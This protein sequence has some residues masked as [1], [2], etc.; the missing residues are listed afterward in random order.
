MKR[1]LISLLI[2]SSIGVIAVAGTSS[3]FSD[4][5]VATD[6]TFQAGGVDLKIDSTAHYN[7]MICDPETHTWQP[8]N[9]E[10]TP[11]PIQFPI[12]GTSCFGSWILT[13][14][15]QERFFDF[16][17]L[18]PGD[19]GE[20]TISMHVVDNN[21]WACMEFSNFEN[22]DPN[23][24]E[25]ES[26][27]D[28]TEG[29]GE[30]ELAQVLQFFAWWDDGDN[31]FEPNN[32]PAEVPLF[33]PTVQTAEQVFTSPGITLA[34]ST[35]GD[36]PIAGGPLEDDSFTSYI[37]WQWCLG[38]LSV[39]EESGDITCD[40]SEIGNEVQTDQLI[41]DVS[42]RIEQARNN[43]DFVCVEDDC[44]SRGAGQA[45]VVEETNQALRRDGSPV[46]TSRSDP[47]SLL[48][49]ADSIG[50]PV[51]GN[52]YSLGFGGSVVIGFAD[53]VFDETGADLRVYEVTGGRPTYPNELARVEVAQT[54]TGPWVELGTAD[55]DK[56]ADGDGVGVD[57][58]D[59]AGNFPW[60]RY[61]RITDVTEL[62]EFSENSFATADGFDID[63]VTAVSMCIDESEQN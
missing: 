47:N 20:N 33:T 26:E 63:A 34:D 18:K 42:F 28:Q 43:P 30:G 44:E 9:P 56:T 15:T 36:G 8:E 54:P 58:F 13:D 62:S 11:S 61:V 32:E 37:G 50:T 38:T 16:T 35:T 24:T 14:L 21:A 4:T 12:A 45:S 55:S 41:A 19:M 39:D 3:F 48:G 5:E 2:V 10:S 22:N 27:V 40:F 1:I 31:V 29:D 46:L 57:T 51:E 49:P 52:F 59:I 6:N 25:P 60:I 7:G 17:D 23:L 53:K